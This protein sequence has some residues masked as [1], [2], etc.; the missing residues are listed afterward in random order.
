M[1][2]VHR[3]LKPENVIVELEE[4]GTEVPRI[5]DFGIAIL[6]SQERRRR[7]GA[8]ITSIGHRARHAAVHGAR[9]GAG[10]RRRITR[11]DLFALGVMVYEMLAGK[12]P[13]DGTRRRD[14]DRR[15]S[16]RIRRAIAERALGIEVDPLLEAFA[17][18]LM[19]RQPRA[20][21]STTRTRRSRC[22]R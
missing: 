5:V 11:T 15:T 1:G 21:G 2:L 10:A 20:I 22:S 18:K 19:A 6:R 14:R 9:A 3:D 4:D 13:F 12:L 8:R 7:R 16:A 17:R